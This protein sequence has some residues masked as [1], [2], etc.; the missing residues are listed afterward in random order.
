MRG[1]KSE[2]VVLANE[3][4]PL[5]PFFPFDGTDFDG[6]KYFEVWRTFFRFFLLMEVLYKMQSKKPIYS[7]FLLL[8]ATY[9]LL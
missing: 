9:R 6:L 1:V 4:I 2:V 3:F 5:R 8:A 7:C